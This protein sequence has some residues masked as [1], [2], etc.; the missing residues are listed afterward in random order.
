MPKSTVIIKDISDCSDVKVLP[1]GATI[2]YPFLF[3]LEDTE[4][5]I[6]LNEP[7]T[8]QIYTND[9]GKNFYKSNKGSTRFSQN[10]ALLA[11]C[12][13]MESMEPEAFKTCFD[14]DGN[15]NINELIGYTFEASV[16]RSQTG[17]FIDWIGTFKTNGV[18]VPNLSVNPTD[19]SDKDFVDPKKMPF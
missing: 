18:A 12:K 14:S 7:S 17:L 11:I 4:G 5:N 19:E 2:K 16:I 10:R 9:W 6:V 13:I 3:L 15:F 8:N 1:G